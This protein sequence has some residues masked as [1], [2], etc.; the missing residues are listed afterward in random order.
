V[1][2]RGTEL[3]TVWPAGAATGKAAWRSRTG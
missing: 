1:Q 3:V 2:W